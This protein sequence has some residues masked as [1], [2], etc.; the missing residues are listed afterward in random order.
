MFVVSSSWG[1]NSEVGSGQLNFTRSNHVFFPI[2]RAGH[3]VW[4]SG[5]SWCCA[6]LVWKIF[7]G[8]DLPR[9]LSLVCVL[10]AWDTSE[11]EQTLL[12]PG[13][14]SHVVSL[15]SELDGQSD[16]IVACTVSARQCGMG[17]IWQF[18]VAI[19]GPLA[20]DRK[21]SI[22][23]SARPSGHN[24]IESRVVHI[25]FCSGFLC[26]FDRTTLTICCWISSL[27]SLVFVHRLVRG[28]DSFTVKWK[29]HLVVCGRFGMNDERNILHSFGALVQ[30]VI[31]LS[32]KYMFSNLVGSFCLRF[33]SDSKTDLYCSFR[34][35]DTRNGTAF[36]MRLCGVV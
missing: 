36:F 6:T 33:L 2:A 23:C 11:P 27:S 34:C 24:E 10:T 25:H 29:V 5:F 17:R 9:Q 20:W 19:F 13:W 22:I 31:V 12:E 8:L 1:Q 26:Y 15:F 4:N 21:E 14:Y 3:L 16:N 28:R 35:A 32:E 30:G 18:A 7:V